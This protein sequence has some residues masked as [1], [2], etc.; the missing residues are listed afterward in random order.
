MLVYHVTKP[1]DTEHSSVSRGILL[2]SV[3]MEKRIKEAVLLLIR[4][5]VLVMAAN[6]PRSVATF[7][8]RQVHI[9]ETIP[10]QP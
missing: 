9:P 7:V 4:N 8:K 3:S 6:Q 2:C 5:N 1:I 10:P